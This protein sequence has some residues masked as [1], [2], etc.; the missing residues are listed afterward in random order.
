MI[1]SSADGGG[2]RRASVGME[3]RRMPK[4][5][6]SITQPAPHRPRRQMTM[7]FLV[8]AIREVSTLG[9]SGRS[10]WLMDGRCGWSPCQLTLSA[11][12][13]AA[14]SRLAKTWQR[15][16]NRR[17]IGLHAA[18]A[19]PQRGWRRR[20]VAMGSRRDARCAS[21]WAAAR[22]K[23]CPRPR[24][25]SVSH[26]SKPQMRPGKRTPAGIRGGGS[27][28]RGPIALAPAPFR[29]GLHE[30]RSGPSVAA[31]RRF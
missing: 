26:A 2:A 4:N 30:P 5:Q 31:F 15:A 14:P 24:C 7:T 25:V 22:R 21:P 1:F 20:P 6:L 17:A 12:T 19:S 9:R 27:V 18:R 13:C 8:G 16:A 11:G 29:R 23:A 3:Q 10:A 28:A